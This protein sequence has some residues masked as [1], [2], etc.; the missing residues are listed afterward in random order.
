MWNSATTVFSKEQA[1][2]P[3]PHFPGF[4]TIK[5]AATKYSF[6]KLTADC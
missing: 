4:F 1:R 3:A 6:Y 2:A 5:P